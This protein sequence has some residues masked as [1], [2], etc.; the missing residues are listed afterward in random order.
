MKSFA[1]Q[2]AEMHEK[3]GPGFL[4]WIA[5]ELGSTDESDE[6]KAEVLCYFENEH[7]PVT[8]VWGLFTQSDCD[9]D[10]R[11]IGAYLLAELAEDP[12]QN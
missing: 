2:V 10:A 5:E 11:L 9:Y 8:G 6:Y 1:R 12:D 7:D 4:C 3:I